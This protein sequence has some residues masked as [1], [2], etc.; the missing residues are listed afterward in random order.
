VVSGYLDNP[1]ANAE[2]FDS[3]GWLRTGD[4]GV[5]D[6]DGYLRIVDRKKDIII[7]SGG[8]N[9]SP[10]S[11]ENELKA[12]RLVPQACVAGER[13]PYLVALLVLDRAEAAAWAAA[14]GHP[15]DDPAELPELRAELAAWVAQVNE[16]FS[17][18]EQVKAFHLVT[19]E[20]GPDSGELTA[21]LKLRRRFVLERYAAAID[22]LYI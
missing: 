14:H 5:F 2:L 18:P 3:G 16:K 8:L 20:W 10:V 17:R 7:T 6:E 22:Q 1:E 19:T 11:V 12:H 13:R 21:T 15:T 9:V 4:V